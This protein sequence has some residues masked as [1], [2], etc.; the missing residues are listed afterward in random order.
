MHAPF[1][2]FAVTVKKCA[3]YKT[4]LIVFAILNVLILSGPADV[5]SEVTIRINGSGSAL[6]MMKPLINAYGEQTKGVTFI[7]ERPIGSAGTIKAVLAGALDVGV[8]SKPL[9]PEE[10]S[11]GGMVKAYGKTP[12]AIV[13]H[14]DVPLRNIS[15]KELEDIY[16]GRTKM[17]AN[18]EKIR[19]IL[20][21]DSDIDTKILKRLSPGMAQA[22]DNA[23]KRGGMLTATTDPDSD[24]AVSGT[25][26]GLGTAGLTSI[27][28]GKSPLNVVA[29]NGVTPS[30]KALAGGAYPLAKDINFLTAGAP[31]A[32]T[33]K[34][35]K[36]VYSRKGRAIA[37]KAGVLV[38]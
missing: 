3:A 37:E 35:L 30:P 12:L 2:F 23:R 1:Y 22:V 21:P 18:G 16:S 25:M 6:E 9:K 32:A 28:I 36:F 7:M 27:R 24:E 26:G 20:R 13:T 11:A 31:S 34:F 5:F 14:G 10:V 19:I 33:A 38:K 29:L 17:W 8:I 4:A 15:T